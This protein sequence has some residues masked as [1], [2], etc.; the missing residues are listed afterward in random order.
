VPAACHHTEI[1]FRYLSRCTPNVFMRPITQFM[2]VGQVNDQVHLPWLTNTAA[3]IP[4]V[5]FGPGAKFVPNV[6]TVDRKLAHAKLCQESIQTDDIMKTSI[7]L[8]DSGRDCN[9][10]E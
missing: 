6:L 1:L 9:L 7:I 3:Y 2:R 4:N 8:P 10:T 5:L